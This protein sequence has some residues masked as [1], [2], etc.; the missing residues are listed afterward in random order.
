MEGNRSAR[1]QFHADT[2]AK[3]TSWRL[4]LE[5]QLLQV[6][7][8]GIENLSQ[9]DGSGVLDLLLRVE[10][11]VA[12]GVTAVGAVA[13]KTV[14]SQPGADPDLED[15]FALRDGALS[16][17]VPIFIIRQRHTDTLA[18]QAVQVVETE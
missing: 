17:E 8:N 16:T 9:G 12:S 10:V 7:S 5:L 6:L 1:L 18:R 14:P 2:D 3:S 4:H 11:V 13:R 15:T